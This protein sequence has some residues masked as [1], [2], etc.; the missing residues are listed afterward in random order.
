T[1]EDFV[2]ISVGRL[3]QAKDYP[4][5]LRAF[6]QIMISG[7]KVELWIA[8][9]GDAVYEAELRA[10]AQK[11]GI[12]A[13]VRWLGSRRDI[14]ALLDAADGFVL[15]SAWEGMPLALGEAMAMRKLVVATDV[16]GVREMMGDTGGLVRAGDSGLLADTMGRM[17][18]LSDIDK[19]RIGEAARVRVL[20]RF[21]MEAKAREWEEVYRSVQS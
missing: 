2:W 15:S 11:L 20:E 3:I 5:L 1:E 18:V 16:G 10:F 4:N 13:Q 7:A 12:E 6:A 14:P 19:A 17:M 21:S 9:Y 8:G